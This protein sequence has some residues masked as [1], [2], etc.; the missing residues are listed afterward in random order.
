MSEYYIISSTTYKNKIEDFP[1]YKKT[2]EDIVLNTVREGIKSIRDAETIYSYRIIVPNKVIEVTF[3][4]GKTEKSVCEQSDTFDL[5]IGL[6]ICLA[7]HMNP[8]L[9]TP[10]GLEE[11]ARVLDGFKKYH[12]M[13]TKA[14]KK[15]E[16]EEKEKEKLEKKTQLDK[17]AKKQKREK[18]KLKKEA[19]REEKK[20]E[21][22]D[23]QAKVIEKVMKELGN[24]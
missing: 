12:N 14:I 2:S 19:R 8:G 15:H 23:F 17:E 3:Y 5:R 9:Y 22:I 18:R 4:D 1:I 11:R 13:V 10:I 7:K 16:K 20:K 24:V 21:A 6:L